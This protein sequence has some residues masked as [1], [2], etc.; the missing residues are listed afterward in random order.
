MQWSH[1][2]ISKCFCKKIMMAKIFPSPFCGKRFVLVLHL[3]LFENSTDEGS[4]IKA[5]IEKFSWRCHEICEESQKS[6][7]NSELP[8]LEQKATL[9]LP[10]FR[11]D[12]TKPPPPKKT[13]KRKTID[14]G[15]IG[16]FAP[17]SWVS[18]SRKMY[19]VSG[20]FHSK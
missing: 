14:A 11:S 2:E 17:S 20:A 10:L 13:R 15:A 18:K 1:Y 5:F 7:K 3:G 4:D 8:I 16:D 6:K 9:S 19:W 12:P